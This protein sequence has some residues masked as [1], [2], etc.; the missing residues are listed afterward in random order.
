[1]DGGEGTVLGTL[2]PLAVSF[3]GPGIRSF[4]SDSAFAHPVDQSESCANWP[5]RHFFTGR[6]TIT[7]T[8]ARVPEGCTETPGMIFRGPTGDVERIDVIPLFDWNVEAIWLTPHF[9]VFAVTAEY[10]SALPQFVR[11][12][13]W[14][15]ETGRWFTSPTRGSL[16]HRP[17]FDLPVLLPDW[18]SARAYET[19]GAVVLRGKTR[20]LALWP[21]KRAWSLV[22]AVT[23]QPTSTNARSVSR[24]LVPSPDQRIGPGLKNEI[25]SVFAKAHDKAN[26]EIVDFNI[27]DLIQT[28]CARRRSQY[29][30]TARAVGRD[31]A[32]GGPQMDWSRELFGVCILDSSL[33]RVTKSFAPFPS[34][35]WADTTVYFDL[36]ASDDSIVVWEEGS[37]YS[38]IGGRLAY[39]C[40]P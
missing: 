19:A 34:Y 40:G 23:G 20:G 8:F 36:D 22:D 26:R 11:I 12:A 13:C 1:M 33:S 2:R 15:L 32:P 17:G 35:R 28:P 38:D 25:R 37:T 5:Y 9:L 10:E 21:E 27:I 14:E 39:P 16:M 31:R 18:Y 29:A 24:T 7:F 4:E 6:D 30:V 3:A